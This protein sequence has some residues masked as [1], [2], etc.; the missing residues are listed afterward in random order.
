MLFSG[1]I[2]KEKKLKTGSILQ[3]ISN[4]NKK[5]ENQAQFSVVKDHVFLFKFL[6]P[7][8]HI[9]PCGSHGILVDQFRHEDSLYS[10]W[11]R[12]VSHVPLSDRSPRDL[13]NRIDSERSEQRSDRNLRHD[14]NKPMGQKIPAL[15]LGTKNGGGIDREG[16]K[17]DFSQTRPRE[18][19]RY[20]PDSDDRKSQ[21]GEDASSRDLKGSESNRSRR[22]GHQD[23]PEIGINKLAL[24]LPGQPPS[25]SGT[26]LGIMPALNLGKLI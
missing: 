8:K 24:P 5:Y 21:S 22:H 12:S 3:L 6:F 9:F 11:E 1:G 16:F 7:K 18:P 10:D 25:T 19:E 20:V 2:F 17:L 4:Q 13:R 23:R 15:K 14:G 26:G